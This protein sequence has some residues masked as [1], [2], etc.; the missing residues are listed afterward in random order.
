MRLR[1]LLCG[2]IGLAWQDEVPSSDHYES[3]YIRARN[4]VLN[5]IIN[6]QASCQS[7]QCLVQ[8]RYK[9]P[10]SVLPRSASHD[11]LEIGKWNVTLVGRL[12]DGSQP[13]GASI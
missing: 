7:T 3:R 6:T 8:N 12:H 2:K 13:Q 11:P 4:R 5:Y 9:T 10:S 1:P